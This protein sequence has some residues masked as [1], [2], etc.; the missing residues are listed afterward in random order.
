MTEEKKQALSLIEQFGKTEALSHV[1]FVLSPR[2][3]L[4]KPLLV[5]Y[6]LRVLHEIRA[7]EGDREI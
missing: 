1:I 4:T 3:N 5:K 6:W 2:F 7:S